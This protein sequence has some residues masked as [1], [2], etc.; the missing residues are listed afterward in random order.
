MWREIYALVSPRLPAS[1]LIT[2]L[3]EKDRFVPTSILATKLNVPKQRPQIVPRDHLISR[4]DDGL[5][6][7]LTL[8][9]APAGFGKTTLVSEWAR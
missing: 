8:I 1:G 4:L 9:S 6:Q 7:R 3:N 2:G 5:V